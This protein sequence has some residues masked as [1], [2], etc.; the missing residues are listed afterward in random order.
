MGKTKTQKEKVTDP[1]KVSFLNSITFKIMALVFAC[2]TLTVVVCTAIL[3]SDAKKQISAVTKESML[4]MATAE[5]NLINDQLAYSQANA[6][7]FAAKLEGLGI[8]GIDS[9]YAYLVSPKGEMLYHPTPE[10]IGQPVENE[11]VKGI[12]S[13]LSAGRVPEDAVVSYEYKGAMKYASYAITDADHFILVI[14]ADEDDVLAGVKKVQTIGIIVAIVLMLVSLVCA[15]IVSKLIVLPIHQVA[16][17]IDDTA[18]FNFRRNPNSAKLVQ[19]KDENGVM[20]RSVSNMRK[21]LRDMIHN[22]EEASAKI[23]GNVDQLQDVTNIVNSMCT[24]NS[25]TTEE[26]AAGMQETAATTESI[27]AN[28]G[29]MQT[30]ARDITQLSQNGDAV[31]DEVMK[32]AVALKSKTMEASNRT[33]SIYESVKVRSDAAVEESKAVYKINELTEAIMAISSQ[34]SL[35]ALNASI[36]AA[37]A[38]EAG[39]GFAVVATEIGNLATQ[40]SQTVGEIDEIVTEVNKAVTNMADCLEETS[41]FLE[42]TVLADYKGFEAVSEQYTDDAQKFKESM[43]DVNVSIVNLADS[44]D[45]ISDA[46]SGINATV[47]ESTLGVTDIAGKTTDM[48]TRTSE[49]NELVEES[50]ECV[51]SLQSIVDQFIMD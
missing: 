26:L 2:V 33:Q 16:E 42:E 29:Y 22:I 47:G 19:R 46:L 4:Q 28:I 18:A 6:D 8:T 39:R 37:R 5:R 15:Y 20:A 7:F 50:K 32:R 38:G 48:V 3:V 25:A 11:V 23:N 17:I 43:R 31:S 36:E 41:T 14:S 24:D 45:K 30:G 1:S 10:K 27:Y 21:S 13:E 9:S 12:V 49:T 51:G 34:T 40:T 35:L 44:I